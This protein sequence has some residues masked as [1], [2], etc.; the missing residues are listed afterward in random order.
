VSVRAASFAA[1]PRPRSCPPGHPCGASGRAEPGRENSAAAILP[2]RTG[3]PSRREP[4]GSPAKN[5]CNAQPPGDVPRSATP[6]AMDCGV[7]IARR[8]PSLS[9]WHPYLHTSPTRPPAPGGHE[10][11]RDRRR[12]LARLKGWTRAPVCDSDPS[13]PKTGRGVGSIQPGDRRPD[14]QGAAVYQGGPSVSSVASRAVRPGRQDDGLRR[15][16]ILNLHA[17]IASSRPPVTPTTQKPRP[18]PAM[19]TPTAAPNNTGN[20]QHA[21]TTAAA[22]MA[23]R[24]WRAGRSTG[25]GQGRFELFHGGSWLHTGCG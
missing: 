6:K 15:L 16:R 23:G 11:N 1:R 19:V 18:I 8:N 2:R 10:V 12:P 13:A 9:E 3:A 7:V 14:R 4:P 24:S 25:I 5:R 20:P 22:R 21:A 17:T